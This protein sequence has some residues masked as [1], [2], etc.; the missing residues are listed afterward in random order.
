MEPIWVLLR[1]Y[2]MIPGGACH[3]LGAYQSAGSALAH[4]EQREQIPIDAWRD[5]RPG[6]QVWHAEHREYEYKLE[7]FM[8]PVEPPAP[9]SSVEIHPIH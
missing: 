2:R 9:P 6:Q 7:A 1:C 5:L 4:A 3:V 8:V